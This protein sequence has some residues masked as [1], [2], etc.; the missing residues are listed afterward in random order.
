MLSTRNMYMRL[1]G[2]KQRMAAKKQHRFYFAKVD[3]K[4]AFD[5]IPQ[6]AI[7][8]VI[9]T[10][11]EHPVYHIDQHVEIAGPELEACCGSALA[12]VKNRTTRRT[13]RSVAKGH[14]DTTGFHDSVEGSFA[15]HKR[16]TVFVDSAFRKTRDAESLAKLAASHIMQNIVKIGKKYYRQKEGIPQG[17]V[18]SSTLCSYF[19]ADLE[20]KELGFLRQGSGSTTAEGVAE[21][22][23]LLL[24]LIDDFLLITTDR[25]KAARFIEVMQRGHPRYGVAVN[26][27]KSLVNFDVE[28]EGQAVPRLAAGNPLFPYCG[29]YIHCSTL[30]MTKDRETKE[31][32]T[33]GAFHCMTKRRYKKTALTNSP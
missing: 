9:G 4:S 21:E 33:C 16:N 19:Y 13:W 14:G 31:Q 24:R 6:E 25:S 2:F 5:T 29:A 22:D 3:V 15:L 32:G 17:S 23:C 20:E 28:F 26:P 10:V 1:K 18:L 27:R 8:K 7:V 11:P 30:N 12:P